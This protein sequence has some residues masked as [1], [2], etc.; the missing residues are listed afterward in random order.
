MVATSQVAEFPAGAIQAAVSGGIRNPLRWLLRFARHKPLGFVGLFILVVFGIGAIFAPVIAPYPFDE[1]DFSARL[2]GPSSSHIFGT[3]NLGRD[4][5]SRILYAT[6]VS[7]FVSFAAVFLA[8]TLATA[9]AVF[10]GFYGGWFDKI[11]QRVI[12]VWLAI[13]G[14]ILLITLMG[15]V[16]PSITSMVLALAILNAPASSRLY[17]SVIIQV[18]SQ[19]YV[20]G[21][22]VLGASDLRIIRLYILPN[23]A[24]I[25]M[26][27]ATVTLGGIII[28]IASLGFLGYG[29]PPPQPDL[30]GM[31]SG[32]GLQF[33]RRLPWLAIWPGLS[34]TLIAFSFNVFGDAIRD[35]MD[36]RLR[37]SR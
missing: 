29:L 4:L 6:R 32:A 14:L 12:D 19:P 2:Q 22:R 33:M 8:K 28:A 13:P 5:F 10:S 31:L 36:P 21:A 17:R 20:E 7:M 16:G 23:I 35:V 26:Y 15:I 25:I 11:L 24:Y 3:D 9:L 37:G 1:A 34:I 18:V 27:S 30:G